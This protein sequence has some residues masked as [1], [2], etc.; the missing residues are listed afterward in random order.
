MY[1]C[2]CMFVCSRCMCVHVYMCMYVY[3][4]L[5]MCMY[6]YVYMYICML[7]DVLCVM[8]VMCVLQPCGKS[9]LVG[10]LPIWSGYIP[11]FLF[12]LSFAA[13]DPTQVSSCLTITLSFRQTSH[14]AYLLLY[15]IYYL[16]THFVLKIYCLL[17]TSPSPRDS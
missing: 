1:V 16:I 11:A 7:M 4:Y 13:A 8:C 6:V 10:T 15:N 2:M 12:S 3:M 5:Y 14:H 9:R 17:Y